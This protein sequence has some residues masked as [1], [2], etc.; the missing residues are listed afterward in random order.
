MAMT[1]ATSSHASGL[2]VGGVQ[3]ARVANGSIVNGIATTTTWSGRWWTAS[4]QREAPY[5]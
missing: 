1:S 2:P 4:S 3:A 5:A